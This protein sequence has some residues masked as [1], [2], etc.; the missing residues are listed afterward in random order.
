MN[1]STLFKNAFFI[2]LLSITFSLESCTEPP[3]VSLTRAQ[4][5]QV[6]TL[7]SRV[8]AGLRA[9]TDSLCEVMMETEMQAAV[10][11]ILELRKAEEI[12]I[13]DRLLKTKQQVNPPQE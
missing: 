10:D 12:K 5:T 4:R 3:P 13:R 8:V 7:F 6:D 1:T 2:G 9:E 11:S